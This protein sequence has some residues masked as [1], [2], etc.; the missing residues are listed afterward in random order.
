MVTY[1]ARE[2]DAGTERRKKL[3]R[4]ILALVCQVFFIFH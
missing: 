3:G 1:K 4:I 2:K